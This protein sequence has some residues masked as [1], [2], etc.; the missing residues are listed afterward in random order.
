MERRRTKLLRAVI[1]LAE[2]G[3][4]VHAGLRLALQ[5]H[6]DIVA[7]HLEADGLGIG[8]GVGLVGSLVQHGGEAEELANR[9]L[10][11]HHFLLI[12]IDRGNAHVA[13]DHDVAAAS[14][15]PAR[16]CAAGA[17]GLHFDLAGEDADLVIVQ[18]RK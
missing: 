8:D 15:R 2:H 1:L 4:H 11:D 14:D 9:G 13:R 7:V 16:R 18:Q 17:Q 6:G 3:E 12:F 10:V 5:Q